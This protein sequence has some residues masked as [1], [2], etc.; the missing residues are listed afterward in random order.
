MLIDIN[1]FIKRLGME[2][3]VINEVSDVTKIARFFVF[4][5][6]RYFL[7]GYFYFKCNLKNPY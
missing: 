5:H 7:L 6:D 1:I 3:F 4:L 2:A